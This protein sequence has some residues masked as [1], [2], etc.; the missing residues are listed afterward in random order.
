M[1]EQ[2]RLYPLSKEEMDQQVCHN[3]VEFKIKISEFLDYFK[4]SYYLLVVI[5]LLYIFYPF[6]MFAWL[7]FSI[8]V[9]FLQNGY[10]IY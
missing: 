2:L 1:Y 10:K 8:R 6:S 9:T 4:S 3:Q 7:F 5:T